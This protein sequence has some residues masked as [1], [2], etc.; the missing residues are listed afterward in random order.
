MKMPYP[1]FFGERSDIPA[2]NT[3][4]SSFPQYL[5]YKRWLATAAALVEY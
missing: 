4:L 2:P 3:L 1:E 5:Q